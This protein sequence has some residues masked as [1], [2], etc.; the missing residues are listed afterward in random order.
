MNK[1]V[2]ISLLVMAVLAVPALAHAQNGC[3]SSPENPTAVL[4]VIGGAACMWPSLRS[5]I[6]TRQK[7]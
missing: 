2:R 1:I 7:K 3:I 6:G 4:G 5:W